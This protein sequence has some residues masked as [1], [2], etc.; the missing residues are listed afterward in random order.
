M[1]EVTSDP[2]STPSS[3]TST[4]MANNEDDEPTSE[5]VDSDDEEVDL[6]TTRIEHPIAEAEY[7]LRGHLRQSSGDDIDAEVESSTSTSSSAPTLSSSLPHDAD[8]ALESG[9]RSRVPTDEPAKAKLHDQECIVAGQWEAAGEQDDQWEVLKHGIAGYAEHVEKQAQLRKDLYIEEERAR[10]IVAIDAL[11]EHMNREMA[12]IQELHQE[13]PG[14]IQFLDHAEDE[15]MIA[16]VQEEVKAVVAIDSGAVANVVNPE[17]VPKCVQIAPNT[18]GKHFRGAND[19]VIEKFGSCTTLMRDESGREVGCRWQVADVTRPLNAVSCITGPE[20]GDAIHNVIFSN[21][22]A[23]VVPPGI[24]E[25]VLKHVTP[26]AEYWR[27]G[28]LYTAEMT[29][30]SF[31]RQGPKA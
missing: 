23:V 3:C 20:E 29:M 31:T 22:R 28:G 27:N 2:T 11:Q 13:T 10:G 14:E 26:V 17:S 8:S 7:R 12:L 24:L 19:S 25:Q 9:E 5:L 1:Q 6:T 16:A 4:S 30:S 18:T 15:G 21:K